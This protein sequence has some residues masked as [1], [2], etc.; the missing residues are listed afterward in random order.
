[1]AKTAKISVVRLNRKQRVEQKQQHLQHGKTTTN[2][3]AKTTTNPAWQ[4]QYKINN[5]QY[6]KTNNK[7]Q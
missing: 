7:Y 3:M 1:M 2:I 5:N 4:K 6:G